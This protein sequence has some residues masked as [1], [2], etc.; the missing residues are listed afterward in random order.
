[1]NSTTGPNPQDPVSFATLLQAWESEQKKRVTGGRSSLA[2]FHYQLKV[3]LEA[4][5]DGVLKGDTGAVNAFEVFSDIATERG[6]YVYL[7]Q[8]K[9]RLNSAAHRKAIEEFLAID[10]WLEDRFPSERERFRYQVVARWRDGHATLETS[11]LS[12]AELKLAEPD[13]SRWRELRGRCLPARIEGSPQVQLAIQLFAHVERP[14]ALLDRCTARLMEKIAKHEAPTDIAGELV[15][16][17]EDGRRRTKPPLKLLSP[18]DFAPVEHP[19]RRVVHGV[20]PTV[21]DLRAGRFMERPVHLQAALEVVYRTWAEMESED[22]SALPVF[23]ITGTSG[24]GKS[25]LALQVAQ[26]LLANGDVEAVNWLESY[27]DVLPGA[28]ANA[29]T[30]VVPLLI[31]GDDLFALENRKRAVWDEVGRRALE[32]GFHRRTAILT[33]GPP[34]HFREFRREANRHRGLRLV[35]FEIKE[36]SADEKI[37]FHAWYQNYTGEHVPWTN[38]AIILVATWIYELHR[39]QQITPEEFANRFHSRLEE[40]GIRNIGRSALALNLYGLPAPDTLFQ[41]HRP[42]LEQMLTEGV[43]RLSSP[44]LQNFAGRFFHPSVCKLVY[45]ALVE[46]SI[47]SARA[48]DIARGFDA[49]LSEGE[50]ADAFIGWLGTQK[51]GR[52]KSKGAA[53]LDEAMRRAIL[54]ALWEGAFAHREP[55]EPM[56]GRLSRWHRALVDGKIQRPPETKACLRSWWQPL[57]LEDTRWG[58]LFEMIWEDASDEDRR[59]ISSTG[60]KWLGTQCSHPKWPWIFVRLAQYE[61]ESSELRALGQSWVGANGAHPWWSYAWIYLA[62]TAER[63]AHLE[64][65]RLAAAALRAIPQQPDIAADLKVWNLAIDLGVDHDDLTQAIVAKLTSATNPYKNKRGID[66][67]VEEISEQQRAPALV[68]GLEADWEAPG[69]AHFWQQLLADGRLSEN[70]LPL[71]RRWLDGREDR[72]E[73]AHVWQVLVARNHELD[74]LLPLGRRWLDGR[75]DRPEWAHVWRVLVDRDRD[76]ELDELLPLG[77][78]WLDGREDRPEWSHVW[79]VLVDRDHN[80]AALLRWGRSWLEDREDRPEWAHVW[81][82]LVARNH[83]LDTLLPLGRRWLDGR[84]DRPEWAHVWRVLVDRDRDHEL[85]ELLP[86]GRRW[87]DGREDRPEWSHVWRV[88]VDRDH[89][90]AALLRW[91][92]SWLEDREDRPEWAHV[93]QVLVARNYDVAALLRW[94][95]SWLEGREDRPE[96]NYVWQVLVDSDHELDTLLPVGRSWLERHSEHEGV[97]RVRTA[98]A[99]AEGRRRAAVAETAGDGGESGRSGLAE[100]LARWLAKH[101]SDG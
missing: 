95:R 26:A 37:D 90:V 30:R 64:R 99:L 44:S 27:A 96:W 78:R 18:A 76:H 100:Q 38:Q 1:M 85:D 45:E 59:I 82:V 6:P 53:L 49:M 13:A 29:S 12:A 91:G 28:L 72:P 101:D 32:G 42:A 66:F 16:L 87:L 10:A 25:V 40:L 14:F 73:W 55:T 39:Q 3:S 63:V 9:T 19:E 35:S 31:Q 92:R 89:N 88:L 70:L 34:E 54:L 36:F 8:V 52:K 43:W 21:E 93:W 83:E 84:E 5:F 69:W 33:C 74:T 41:G 7:T 15:Q 75:E 65:S 23:W 71:G 67:M 20:R 47:R 60:Q 80:V 51:I 2:G 50:P 17:F 98:L 79:R 4:F 11:S 62:Q 58:H 24:A 57:P 61:S 46:P 94:G 81:Q 56:V 77:R 97:R 68:S 86:L 48:T 22:G